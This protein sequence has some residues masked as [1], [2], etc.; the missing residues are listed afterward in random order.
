MQLLTTTHSCGS[1]L[2]GWRELCTLHTLPAN[3]EDRGDLVV[4]GDSI[5]SRLPVQRG[6]LG[7][8]SSVPSPSHCGSA[9]SS[10]AVASTW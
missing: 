2:Q 9:L 4:R 5:P 1:V 8:G 10:A 7:Q 6:P 3:K